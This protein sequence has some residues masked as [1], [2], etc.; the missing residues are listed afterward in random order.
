[1]RSTSDVVFFCPNYN[2]H[3]AD[4]LKTARTAK[5]ALGLEGL[6]AE[7]AS[8][9]KNLGLVEVKAKKNAGAKI[10]LG[11]EGLE[12]KKTAV[13]DELS[14]DE[15]LKAKKKAREMLKAK[16]KAEKLLKAKKKAAE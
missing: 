1:M 11:L 12:A 9:K 14:L 15:Y 10:A 5:I 6:K 2:I 7:K 4:P 8:A 3:K 16:K 13:K